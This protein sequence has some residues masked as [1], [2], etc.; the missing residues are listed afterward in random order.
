MG[1]EGTQA[2][3]HAGTEGAE[4]IAGFETRLMTL[5][6]NVAALVDRVG[7]VERLAA[8]VAFIDG[9]GLVN[10]E[11]LAE[12]EHSKASIVEA[13][14]TVSPATEWPPVAAGSRGERSLDIGPSAERSEE[15]PAPR[16]Q[17]IA[18]LKP[19]Q[20]SVVEQYARLRGM[21]GELMDSGRAH[22]DIACVA[23]LK[24]N[25]RTWP[26]TGELEARL[27]AVGRALQLL[28]DEPAHVRSARLYGSGLSD[29]E[30]AELIA[31][32]ERFE[33]GTHVPVVLR[34][35]L[36]ETEAE[37]A[38]AQ[39]ERALRRVDDDLTVGTHVDELA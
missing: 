26:T 9:R 4:A 16:P 33:A 24:I 18:N 6:S 34:W 12:F 17:P 3:R 7:K 21:V 32:W 11:Q 1:Q 28:A 30:V 15:P 19:E 37:L 23:G 39:S 38:R 29:A 31:R 20:A 10:G 13:G 2:R 27:L 8:G 35:T 5:A 14:S 25:A 22:R 36:Q